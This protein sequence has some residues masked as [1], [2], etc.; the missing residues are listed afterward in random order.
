MRALLVLAL[1]LPLTA[2]ADPVSRLSIVGGRRE[3]FGKVA[4]RWDGG[5]IRGVEAGIQPSW[6]G[7]AWAL[8]FTTLHAEPG[9]SLGTVDTWQIDVAARARARLPLP[10]PAQTFL[11]TQLGMSI[12]RSEIPLADGAGAG[13]FG[14]ITGA[15]LDIAVGGLQFGLAAGFN[16]GFDG[17]ASLDVR[18]S[19]GYGRTVQK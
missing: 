6:M 8:Y 10:I 11:H 1:L 15:G 18:L 19:I 3:N 12:L 2:G 14:A 7:M 13:S 17:S 9:M 16:I 5:W 4:E